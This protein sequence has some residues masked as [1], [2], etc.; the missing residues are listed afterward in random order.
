[1]HSSMYYPNE[2]CA[3]LLGS[4]KSNYIV[5]YVYLTN[6][7]SLSTTKFSISS[8]E[9]INCYLFANSKKLEMIGIFHSHPR[10]ISY[11]SQI[12]KKFMKLNQV[13]WIIF[14]HV[15]NNFQAFLLDSD[16]IVEIPIYDNKRKNKSI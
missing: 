16:T 8:N 11:P 1:M 9:L 13:C 12:D 6:N 14:S 4:N 2:S 3:L 7:H 10:S 15:Q 5:D